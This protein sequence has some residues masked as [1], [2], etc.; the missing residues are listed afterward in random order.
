VVNLYLFFFFF[1]AYS[2]AL[3][4]TPSGTVQ[5]GTMSGIASNPPPPLT[6]EE[7][8][9]WVAES[10]VG[11]ASLMGGAVAAG[12]GTLLNN[13]KEYGPHWGGFGK[14][15]G[16]RTEGVATSNVMEAGFG[17]FWGEDPRYSRAGDQ[18]FKSRIGN[19]IKM[20]FLAKDRNGHLMPAYSRYLAIPGSNFLSNTWR[21]DSDAT[22]ARATGRTALG[23]LARMT[24]NAFDEFWPD[25][26]QRVFKRKQP[27]DGN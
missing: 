6:G 5:P 25:V 13:P 22:A 17:S 16:L 12:W 18:P 2:A 27:K 24:G 21:P 3:A 20:T 11:P 14:R 9:K 4:Q 23:F 7:R 26:K 8:L 19:V 10:T 1:L 15:Y